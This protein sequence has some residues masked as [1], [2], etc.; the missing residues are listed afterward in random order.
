ML[1]SSPGSRLR[2][3]S[4]ALPPS[5]S[6]T[7]T[8]VTS[9]PAGSTGW[10]SSPHAVSGPQAGRHMR[11]LQRDS[12]GVEADPQP[13]ARRAGDLLQRPGRRV[14]ATALK[15]GH[16]RLRRLRALGKLRLGERGAPVRFGALRCA[17]MSVRA[18]SNSGPRRS[19]VY[20]VFDQGADGGTL[21]ERCE[22]PAGEAG[23]AVLPSR[24]RA[25]RA[26]LRP[27]PTRAGAR[28]EAVHP[29]YRPSRGSDR[30]TP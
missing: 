8:L 7:S 18:N 14:D 24:R 28:I 15:A 20:A 11:H 21:T 19:H 4:R 27:S 17:S 2:L 23:C 25:D 26:R 3:S 5:V 22:A 29:R 30:Q 13:R 10:V 16:H 6:R 12:G 9:R 1:P